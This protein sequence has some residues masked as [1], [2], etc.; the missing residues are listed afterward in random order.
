[1]TSIADTRF[2]YILALRLSS[3]QNTMVGLD[4]EELHSIYEA[5]QIATLTRGD[6]LLM[7]GVVHVDAEAFITARL[8]EAML[9][10]DARNHQHPRAEITG[11]P[12]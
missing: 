12:V 7:D 1:M 11:A 6:P 5:D 9:H 8:A 4:T 2:H 3:R 10:P